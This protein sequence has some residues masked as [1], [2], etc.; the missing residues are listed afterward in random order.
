MN[1]IKLYGRFF[2]ES[3][4]ETVKNF[5]VY[6][7]CFI[8]FILADFFASIPWTGLGYEDNSFYSIIMNVLV[9]LANLIIVVQV[10][11]IEKSRIKGSD[12]EK[13]LYAAPTYLIYT[14]YYSI[15]MLIGLACFIVPGIILGVAL[16][17]V[18][19]AAVL[20]DNDSI[21][22]FKVSWKMAKK[23]SV[24]IVFFVLS[25]IVTEL[26]GLG[27]DFIPDWRVKLGVNVVY[28]FIDA[29]VMIVITKVSVKIFYHLKAVLNDPS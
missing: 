15:L 23:D 10:I 28:S 17:M 22:Y 20:I 25:S 24:L 26:V 6:A 4:Q 8:F 18:P 21:N 5:N 27:L 19:L 2:K 29:L 1:S 3:Y 11:L 13:L 16:A 7:V 9:G 14:I 12:K